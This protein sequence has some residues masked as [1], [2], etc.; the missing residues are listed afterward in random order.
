MAGLN[1]DLSL[2]IAYAHFPPYVLATNKNGSLVLSGMMPG[3]INS[4]ARWMN[5]SSLSFIREPEDKYGTWENN[6]FTGMVGMLYRNEVDLIMNP[7]LAKSSILEFAYFTNPITIGAY[8]VLSGKRS[9]QENLFLY[10]SALDTVVWYFIIITAIAISVT[11]TFMFSSLNALPH[12]SK[13]RICGEYLWNLVSYMLRQ[14]PS[15]KLLLRK[16][17]RKMSLLIQLMVTLWMFG[18]GLLVMSSFQSLLVSKMTVYKSTPI[19]DTLEDLLYTDATVGVAPFEIQLEDVLE[20]SG[21]A[22]YEKAWLKIKPNLMPWNKVLTDETI[23]DTERGKYCIIH[24]YFILRNRLS[25]FLKEKSYC[26]LH[27]SKKNFFPFPLLVAVQKTLPRSFF[28]AFNLGITRSVDS[29]MPGKYFKPGLEDSNMCTS[30]TDKTLKPQGLE[31]L[32][33]VLLLWAAGLACGV[34]ALLYE[35]TYKHLC[36]D[37]AFRGF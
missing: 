22:V 36:R 32:Y 7:I 21:V 14:D 25:R 5:I 12:P 29:D 16:S 15:H 27:L 24:G 17:K 3:I 20:N 34:I 9:E 18:V 13:A 28:E 11:S 37:C 23:K 26:N 31:N 1:K 33:G 8:T 6:T 19:I 10:F 4:V 35:L 30:Y 2:R